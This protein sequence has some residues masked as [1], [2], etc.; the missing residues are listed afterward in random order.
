MPQR[1]DVPG[2]REAR[3][4]DS[5]RERSAHGSGSRSRTI[6]YNPKE[7][8]DA[9]PAYHIR[10]ACPKAGAERPLNEERIKKVAAIVIIPAQS[11]MELLVF[12]HPLDEGGFMIQLP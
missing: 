7:S 2:E 11:E 8:D 9:R 5:W 3:D 4:G 12:Y 6:C 1:G 10:R